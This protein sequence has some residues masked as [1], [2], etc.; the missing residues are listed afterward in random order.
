MYTFR[1]C[2]LTADVVKVSIPISQRVLHVLSV[3]VA[4]NV[5]SQSVIQRSVLKGPTLFLARH[6]VLNA[7]QAS[8]VPPLMPHPLPA[9]RDGILEKVKRRVTLVLPVISVLPH[10]MPPFSVLRATTPTCLPTVCVQG[11]LLVTSVLI[12]P[13]HH[14][15][16]RLGTS[17]VVKAHQYAQW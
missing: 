14:S 15:P 11:V 10:L 17:L 7:L 5:L 12:P 16:V 4:M 6:A 8:A 2:S 13:Y 9:L 3:Q 1:W